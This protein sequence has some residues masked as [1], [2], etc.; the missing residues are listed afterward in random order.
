MAKRHIIQ[1][2]KNGA[3]LTQVTGTKLQPIMS[4]CK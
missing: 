1:F 2:N 4:P 3:V